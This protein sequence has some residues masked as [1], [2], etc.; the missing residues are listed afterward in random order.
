MWDWC[1]FDLQIYVK[2]STKVKKINR[3]MQIGC[4]K[5]AKRKRT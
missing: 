1:I 4:K 2:I 3:K 5:K